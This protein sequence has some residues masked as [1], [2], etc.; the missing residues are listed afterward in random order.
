M[1]MSYEMARFESL[2]CDHEDST[3]IGTLVETIQDLLLSAIHDQLMLP[4]LTC[5]G[6]H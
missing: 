6:R 4:Y 2:A 1:T 5:L 3:S